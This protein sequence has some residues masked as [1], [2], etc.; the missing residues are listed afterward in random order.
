MITFAIP[1]YEKMN[2]GPY[3]LLSIISKALTKESYVIYLYK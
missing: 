3:F 1:P 2:F